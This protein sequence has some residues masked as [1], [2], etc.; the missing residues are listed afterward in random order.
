MPAIQA[1]IQAVSI[2]IGLH[3][4]CW[5]FHIMQNSIISHLEQLDL[6]NLVELLSNETMEYLDSLKLGG[7]NEHTEKLRQTITYIQYLITFKKIEPG[8]I[9]TMWR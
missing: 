6:P 7:R 3:I 5:R 4:F 9:P 8:Q 1:E 2:K